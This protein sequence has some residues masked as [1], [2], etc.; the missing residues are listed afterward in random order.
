MEFLKRL[1][2]YGCRKSEALRRK[3]LTPAFPKIMPLSNLDTQI[4]GV[5]Q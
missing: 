3:I 4:N 2:S 1:V 5:T